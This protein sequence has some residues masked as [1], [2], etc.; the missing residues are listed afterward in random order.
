MRTFWLQRGAIPDLRSKIDAKV[1]QAPLH[2]DCIQKPLSALISPLLDVA[3]VRKTVTY[4]LEFLPYYDWIRNPNTGEMRTTEEILSG[5]IPRDFPTL[6]LRRARQVVEIAMAQQALLAGDALLP[7]LENHLIENPAATDLEEVLADNPVLAANL[8]RYCLY[9]RVKDNLLG[10]AF[11][12]GQEMPDLVQRATG[13]K[14]RFE[15]VA[16]QQATD[17]KEARPK[18]WHL[19]AGKLALPLPAAVELRDGELRP[20][21][22]LAHLMPTYSE[23]IDVLVEESFSEKHFATLY[24]PLHRQSSSAA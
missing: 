3:F 12:L 1:S 24:L 19:V 22:G 11:S 23:L 17:D 18:V 9:D 15:K 13:L 4:V 8:V 7:L 21:Q 6:L 2:K 10:Y 20:T 14:L 5:S 16:P